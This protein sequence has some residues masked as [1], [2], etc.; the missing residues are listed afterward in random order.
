[1]SSLSMVRHVSI[2]NARISQFVLLRNFDAAYHSVQRCPTPQTSV[3]RNTIGILTATQERRIL[4]NKVDLAS[5]KGRRFSSIKEY[6]KSLE[7]DT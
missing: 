5:G 2:D 4:K 3:R 6:I 7:E 1:M